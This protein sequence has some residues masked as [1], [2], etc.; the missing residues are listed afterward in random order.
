MTG[1]LALDFRPDFDR[2]AVLGVDGS[3][4]SF[5][6]VTGPSLLRVVPCEGDVVA[7]GY[8]GRSAG[9]AGSQ[10]VERG[11]E[12]MAT[13]HR[14]VTDVLAAEPTIVTAARRS[15]VPPEATLE[16]LRLVNRAVYRRRRIWVAV[17]M[18]LLVGVLSLAGGELAGRLTGT[19]GIRVVEAA[20]EPVTYLVQPGDTLWSIAAEVNPAGS[21]IRRTVDR[22]VEANGGPVVE[23]GQQIVLSVG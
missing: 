15:A 22:L 10:V 16:P 23:P 18:G 7:S 12:R 2:P 5:P 3:D 6:D 14:L 17:V 13:V 11:G 4:P 8:S 9:Q 21:D 19:P 1:Q 20:V